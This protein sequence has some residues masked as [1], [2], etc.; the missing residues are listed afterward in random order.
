[1]IQ[2][3]QEYLEV[4]KQAIHESAIDAS[5]FSSIQTMVSPKYV[6]RN[7]QEVHEFRKE[8]TRVCE[9]LLK[10]ESMFLEHMKELDTEDINYSIAYETLYCQY[11][12]IYNKEVLHIISK[13]SK[14][15]I[16]MP[17]YFR[18]LYKPV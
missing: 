13:K 5:A 6:A 10:I 3:S 11:L 8:I 7:R 1:M 12:E 17:Y 9:P 15:I 16:V 4:L 14:W 18:N 2:S